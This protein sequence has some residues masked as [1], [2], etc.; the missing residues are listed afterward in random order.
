MAEQLGKRSIA[1]GVENQRQLNFLRVNGCNFVQGF[2]YSE[3]LEMT[4]FLNFVE[5]QDFHT[6]RRRALEI[7]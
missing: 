7:I 5:K 6:Q 2:Y 3:A 1:E 4:V